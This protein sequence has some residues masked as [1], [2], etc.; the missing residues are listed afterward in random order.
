MKNECM[1]KIYI[2]SNSLYSEMRG[3]IKISSSEL[4]ILKALFE[5]APASMG[6]DALLNI[7]WADRVVTQNSLNVAITNIRSA[8]ETLTGSPGKEVITYCKDTVAKGYRLSSDLRLIEGRGAVDAIFGE[9]QAESSGHNP[10]VLR[11][12]IA[13][14]FIS[15]LVF[16]YLLYGLQGYRVETYFDADSRLL[17]VGKA[18]SHSAFKSF[19]PTDSIQMNHVRGVLNVEDNNVLI[20]CF[21]HDSVE[22]RVVSL[23]AFDQTVNSAQQ[24]KVCE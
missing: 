16:V 20:E 11:L 6:K 12:S 1:I 17:L 7:G 19:K 4:A 10:I 15:M 24:I 22:R 8:L 2:K 9:S 13:M 18:L 23:A 14:L 5:T 3:P 21:N